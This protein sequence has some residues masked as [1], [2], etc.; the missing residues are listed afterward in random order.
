MLTLSL[1]LGLAV[2]VSFFFFEENNQKFSFSFRSIIGKT[3]KSLSYTY[4]LY[5]V[6]GVCLYDI[7]I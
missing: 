7:N 1:T 4:I 5:V 2:A 6:V 3:H